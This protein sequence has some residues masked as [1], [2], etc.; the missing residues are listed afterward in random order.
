MLVK[1]IIV[2]TA[3]IVRVGPILKTQTTAAFYNYSDVVCDGWFPQFSY[4]WHSLHEM[5]VGTGSLKLFFTYV[6]SS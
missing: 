4:I 6:A 5:F 2:K 1:T 3:T